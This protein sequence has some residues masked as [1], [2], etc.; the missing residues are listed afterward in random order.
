M[1][2]SCWKISNGESSRAFQQ[3]SLFID[4]ILIVARV[5]TNPS[6]FLERS[7]RHCQ[8]LSTQHCYHLCWQKWRRRRRSW[9]FQLGTFNRG[10]SSG[11]RVW[12]KSVNEYILFLTRVRKFWSTC[13]VESFWNLNLLKIPAKPLQLCY[14]E[15][16][17]PKNWIPRLRNSKTFDSQLRCPSAGLT[18]DGSAWKMHPFFF[19]MADRNSLTQKV[20]MILKG[21]LLQR[22]L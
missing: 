15:N 5:T 21:R 13:N 10:G 19:V 16:I 17:E 4:A 18:N 6:L 8:K 11:F 22:I 14:N 2:A 1:G 3:Q 9:V 7:D 20:Y 12:T